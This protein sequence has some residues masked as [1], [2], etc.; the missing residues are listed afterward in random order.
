M[1][2]SIGR[3]FLAVNKSLS[4]SV[5]NAIIKAGFY[6]MLGPMISGGMQAIISGVAAKQQLNGLSAER[7]SLKTHGPVV[8]GL[9]DKIDIGKTKIK[10]LT[11]SLKEANITPANRDTLIAQKT[12]LEEEMAELKSAKV[13]HNDEKNKIDQQA[14]SKAIMAEILKG[15]VGSTVPG[16]ASQWT[17]EVKAEEN[18]LQNTQNAQSKATDAAEQDLRAQLQKLVELIADCL[19]KIQD[20]TSSHSNAFSA[21][22][23]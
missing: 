3:G 17:G 14:K 10:D 18:A 20:T 22:K 23:A 2:T 11:A 7:Q 9:E 19:R 5:G 13:T 4:D 1:T 21:F 12:K 8:S 15:V 6:E 16:F